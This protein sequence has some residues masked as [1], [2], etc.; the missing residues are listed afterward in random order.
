MTLSTRKLGREGLEV[1]AIG[2]GCM[3]MS[4]S[5]GPAD[6][7]ES[8]ATLHRAIELGC[9]FLDTAEVYG[10]FINEDLL[11]RALKGKRGQVTI[12]T[13]FGFD[14]GGGKASMQLNSRPDTIRAAVEGS[15]QAAADRCDRP[16]V[17]ASHRSCRADRGRG[18]HG[19]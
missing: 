11:G 17:P 18:R 10:P 14:L 2:L 19:R 15:P 16:S 12:A 3:G 6:E 9:T 5:Y 13:K 7:A 4:Q 8:I 1:S